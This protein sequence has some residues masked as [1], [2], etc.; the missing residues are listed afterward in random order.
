[1][2]IIVHDYN[3]NNQSQQFPKPLTQFD[4]LVPSVV[5]G[6]EARH[7]EVLQQFGVMHIEGGEGEQLVVGASPTT[8]SPHQER[9]LGGEG[10]HCHPPAVGQHD[11]ASRANDDNIAAFQHS[12]AASDGAE[13][14]LAVI[15]FMEQNVPGGRVFFF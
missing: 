10:V 2:I 1:M 12:E 13:D 4:G 9:A 14:D 15:E 5:S 3:S 8:T 11:A 7:A 6:L